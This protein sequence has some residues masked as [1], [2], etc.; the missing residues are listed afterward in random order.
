MTENHV[1]REDWSNHATTLLRP[2]FARAGAALPAFTSTGQ[3]GSR[4]DKCRDKLASRLLAAYPIDT[5]HFAGLN[6]R[7]GA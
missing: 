7:H 4:I 6:Q 2:H 5:A 3:H 1:T